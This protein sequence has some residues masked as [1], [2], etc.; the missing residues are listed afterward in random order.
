MNHAYRCVKEA[1]P[2]KF[3]KFSEPMRRELRVLQGL[4][5]ACAEWDLAARCCQFAFCSDASDLGCG[6][7]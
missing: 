4:V 2:G 1:A 7:A 6:L 5:F 3:T